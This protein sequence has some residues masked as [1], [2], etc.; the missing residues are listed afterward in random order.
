MG[1]KIPILFLKTKST[2]TD[3][4]EDL[5]SQQHIHDS[6][7]EPQFVP[8]LRHTF[9]DNGMSEVRSVLRDRLVNE[10][11]NAKYGG[12]IFTSQ[13]AVEA[14]TVL[15]EEAQGCSYISTASLE[16]REMCLD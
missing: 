5:F 7:L 9:K 3:A 8:V 16:Q 10:Q 6:R 13:R 15:V 11:P 12:I 4:Y 14:F 2:P 1:S